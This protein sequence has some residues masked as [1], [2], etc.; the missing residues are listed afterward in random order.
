MSVNGQNWSKH[1]WHKIDVFLTIFNVILLLVIKLMNAYLN[2]SF[3]YDFLPEVIIFFKVVLSLYTWLIPKEPAMYI[4]SSGIC[5][6]PCLFS[7]ANFITFKYQGFLSLKIYKKKNFK[8]RGLSFDSEPNIE[9]KK[10]MP[11]RWVS[12]L[13]SY[14]LIRIISP[15]V[16]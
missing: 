14:V 13:F 15:S 12:W 2:G 5:I 11:C 3:K 4:N 6:S 10:I 9:L 1:F 16:C 7:N 8:K